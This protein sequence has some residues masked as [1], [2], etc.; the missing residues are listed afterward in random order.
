MDLTI[1]GG[2]GGRKAAA[3]LLTIDPGA[4]IIVSSGYSKD[5]TITNYKKYGFCASLPKPYKLETISRVLL[6]VFS[7]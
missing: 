2:M 1:P 4:K 3:Q 5:D 7:G 6:S